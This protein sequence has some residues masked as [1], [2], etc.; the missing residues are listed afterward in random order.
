[1]KTLLISILILSSAFIPHSAFSK[2]AV[3]IDELA[4]MY[5]ISRCAE[6]HPDKYE[7]WK[8]STMGNSIIDPRVLRGMRS[9]IRLAIDEEAS[10][11]RKDLYYMPELSYPADKRR[12]S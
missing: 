3:T 8:T 7:D 4:K 11:T 10:L 1:M 6:C 9:F 12:L 5:D 2:Q